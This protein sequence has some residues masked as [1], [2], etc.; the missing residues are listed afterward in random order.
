M[1]AST[2]LSACSSPAG[3]RLVGRG[4]VCLASAGTL[5]GGWEAGRKGP[6]R[7]T[8]GRAQHSTQPPTKPPRRCASPWGAPP[9]PWCSG[10]QPRLLQALP[11]ALHWPA[12]VTKW[13]WHGTLPL[14]QCNS[15]LWET[16]QGGIGGRGLSL[17]RRED[18]AKDAG[19]PQPGPGVPW[20]GPVIKR[21]RLAKQKAPAGDCPQATH[22]RI[23]CKASTCRSRPGPRVSTE[24]GAGGA[25]GEGGGGKR[26]VRSESAWLRGRTEGSGTAGQPGTDR[27]QPRPPQEQGSTP[28]G[29][30]RAAM[31]TA[32]CKA[33]PWCR[34]LPPPP[35][36]KCRRKCDLGELRAPN[37]LLGH[38]V[39]QVPGLRS[40]GVLW[41][42]GSCCWQIRTT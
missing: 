39:T 31:L 34:S 28:R 27:E 14:G 29:A 24:N 40:R 41:A 42:Q 1:A 3:R 7:L 2:R 15:V 12:R 32:G 6:G 4:G 17:L 23:T 30:A 26:T 9:P 10:P 16:T 8:G 33:R 18:R 19:Q 13:P 37:F 38:P 22:G 11:L 35:A 20:T 36:P 5:E 21:T 25:S